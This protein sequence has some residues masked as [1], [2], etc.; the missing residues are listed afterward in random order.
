MKRIYIPKKR[1]DVGWQIHWMQLKFPGFHFSKSQWRGTLKPRDKSPDYKIVIC[2]KGKKDP[3][4]YLKHPNLSP[5][6]PH[7]Y[8]DKAL[9]LYYPN[10]WRWSEEKI[11]A[12]T[13]VPWTAFWLFCYE[14]WLEEGEWYNEEAPHPR[15]NQRKKLRRH[16]RH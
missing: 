16:R 10:D 7:V 9:C 1:P 11:I 3:K 15:V 8:G 5:D 13:I 6:T 4:V 14:V 2:Y 12:H